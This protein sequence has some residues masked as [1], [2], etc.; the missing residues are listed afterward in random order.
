MMPRAGVISR[1]CRMTRLDLREAGRHVV[2][3]GDD[4]EAVP[5]DE[6]DRRPVG[7]LDRLRDGKPDAEAGSRQGVTFDVDPPCLAKLPGVLNPLALADFSSTGPIARFA[8][9]PPGP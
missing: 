5:W 4:R 1:C 9:E 7:S 2:H 6:A 3:S 8:S